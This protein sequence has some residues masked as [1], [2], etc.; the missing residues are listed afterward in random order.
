MTDKGMLVIV[1]CKGGCGK[2]I[3]TLR[4][5]LHGLDELHK[6]YSGYCADCLP[7]GRDELLDAMGKGIVDVL[8]EGNVHR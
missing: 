3:T 4:R 8:V 2:K 6:Q 1:D 7:I 5:S